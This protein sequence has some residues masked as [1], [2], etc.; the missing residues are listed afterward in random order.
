MIQHLLPQY[1]SL[2]RIN[3]VTQN[4]LPQYYRLLK[5]YKRK[6]SIVLQ[7]TQVR[8]LRRFLKSDLGNKTEEVKFCKQ[9]I[10]KVSVRM[11]NAS[12]R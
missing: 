2:L 12:V 11:K 7:Y 4:P 9:S 3:K 10:I 6:Y 1:Y 8:I 5:I